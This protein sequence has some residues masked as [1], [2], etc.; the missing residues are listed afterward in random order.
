M[1]AL[2]PGFALRNPCCAQSSGVTVHGHPC[3]ACVAPCPAQ[4]GGGVA[5]PC[6]WWPLRKSGLY[7]LLDGAAGFQCAMV[8][9]LC[10][11]FSQHSLPVRLE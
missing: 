11:D 5:H 4:R 1:S 9:V 8:A 3:D 2:D 10:G 7:Y 6:A